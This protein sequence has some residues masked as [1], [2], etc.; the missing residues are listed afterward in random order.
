MQVFLPQPLAMHLADR[1]Q[2]F[3]QH[4]CLLIGQHRQVFDLF[5]GI[6]QAFGALKEIEQQPAALAFLQAIGQQQWRGQALIGEQAHAVQLTLKMPRGFAADQQFGQHRTAAPDTGTDITLPRQNPQ[7]AQQLQIGGPGGIGQRNTQRQARAAASVFQFGQTHQR[8]LLVAAPRG[9]SREPAVDQ[10]TVLRLIQIGGQQLAQLRF[11]PLRRP[12]QQRLQVLDP[13]ALT[14][15]QRPGLFQVDQLGLI[16]VTGGLQKNML[17]IKT[18]VHLAPAVQT[19][20]QLPAGLEDG[21]V[22]RFAQVRP[23]LQ[24]RIQVIPTIQRAGQQ[25][26]ADFAIDFALTEEHRLQRRNAELLVT[27]DVAKLAGKTRLAK[28]RMQGAHQVVAL[29]LEVE[30]M[31][32]QIQSKH[33]APATAD[34]VGLVHGI[35][36]LGPERIESAEAMALKQRTVFSGQEIS[37]SRPSKNL[38]T[39]RIRFLSAALSR[40]RWR[41]CR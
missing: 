25:N 8:V 23:A 24:Q 3:G 13:V 26:R 35:E 20:R 38:T 16:A 39:C 36:L 17:G 2:R 41:Y 18:A 40:V 7:Q 33:A 37:H 31:T 22:L 15:Q 9:Q 34:G 6:P 4:G 5:P 14:K 10:R 11:A 19:P 32:F 30:T 29:A 28:G 27:A 1:A 12:T 21:R